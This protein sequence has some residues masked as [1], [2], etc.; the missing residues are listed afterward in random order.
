MENYLILHGHFYQPGREDPEP[1]IIPL[2]PSAAPFHDWN[3]R[4]TKECYEA[5]SASRVLNND[6]KIIDIVNNYTYL[7]FNFGPTLLD[8]LENHAKETY[9]RII[10]ADRKSIIRN[11]GHGN[12]VAQG[13][14][15]TILPLD[16]QEDIET[17]I[18][19]G[20]D[21]FRR[22]FRRES[23]GIWLP[24]A[25]VNTTVIDSL[26]K[27]N[28]KFIILSPC[29]AEAIR[30]S[31]DSNW[32][33]F[34]NNNV[35]SSKPFFIRGKTGSIAVFF[36]NSILATGISFEHYLRNADQLYSKLLSFSDKDNAANL[37]HTATDGE[38]YGHHEPFGDMCLSSL[39]K[40]IKKNNDFVLSNYGFYLEKYPP[41]LEVRLRS[42]EDKKGTSWSCSHGISRWYKDCGCTTGGNP[43]WNQEWRTP[44]RAAFT[45][46]SSRLNEVYKKQMYNLT[47]KD[48]VMILNKYGAVINGKK[49]PESFSRKYIPEREQKT[50]IQFL[51]LLE[52]QKYRLSMFTSCGWFF[53][54]ISGLE[55]VQNM[56]YASQALYL[57]SEYLLPEDKKT[58][59]DI[60]SKAVSNIKEKSTGKEIFLSLENNFPEGFQ[61]AL[62]FCS[63]SHLL[64]Q[65]YGNYILNYIKKDKKEKYFLEITNSGTTE[66]FFYTV[67]LPE[68]GNDDPAISIEEMNNHDN[69]AIYK[70]L[71][72]INYDLRK[73]ILSH[74]TGNISKFKISELVFLFKYCKFLGL[75]VSETINGNTADLTAELLEGGLKDTGKYIPKDIFHDIIDLINLADYHNISFDPNTAQ[76]IIF[77]KINTIRRNHKNNRD[78]F[79][80]IITVGKLM[81][82]YCDDL[83]S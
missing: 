24:E 78:C 58:F 80:R 71:S 11:N 61:A 50:R 53:S 27:H 1:G 54:D 82:I 25:A 62:H 14:N 38:I 64:P 19:W 43:E 52:G 77:D 18:C 49:S 46:I 4:I 48:P 35:P 45:Y 81:G 23:E 74:G 65:S 75:P 31:I 47:R 76:N 20:L 17:Q 60:L 55:S 67:I 42:G 40:L 72:G 5:N 28:I 22:H 37:V 33:L 41:V 6:G 2:Q 63:T 16:T 32:Q 83:T 29:Q 73:E 3:Y 56:K 30:K 9:H 59:L 57:Y 12:A 79:N 7:S 10:E 69:N 34:Q 70:D 13:Y 39:I 36:Y 51:K 21:N 66:T 44:L 68:I 8:W 15:H 26:I